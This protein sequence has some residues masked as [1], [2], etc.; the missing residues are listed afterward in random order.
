MTQKSLVRRGI[1]TFLVE[2]PCCARGPALLVQ[3]GFELSVCR[4]EEND[5]STMRQL[6]DA[7][8]FPSHCPP[9]WDRASRA[10]CG[11]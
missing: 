9:L 2:F 6:V 11:F 8:E 4:R 10:L 3:V 7:S 1:D 5:E